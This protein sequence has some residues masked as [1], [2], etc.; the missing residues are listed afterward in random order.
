MRAV[1]FCLMQF[2][3]LAERLLPICE[4]FGTLPPKPTTTNVGEDVSA[5]SVF[6]NAFLLLVRLW[7]FHRAPVE[8]CILG[9]GAPVGAEMNLEYLLQLRNAQLSAS[10]VVSSSSS[11]NSPGTQ[12]ISLDSFPKLKAWYV[13]HSASIA[14]TLSSLARGHPVHQHVDRLLSM[15]LKKQSK[16]AIS[17]MSSSSSSV[18]SGGEETSGRPNLSAWEVM[19]ATPYIV[20]AVL[21]ACA[22]GKLAPR[23]LTTGWQIFLNCGKSIV[24]L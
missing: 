19:T 2:P 14:A 12:L 21:A 6:S 15:M 11:S 4:F 23:D 8:Y 3:E 16:G 5:Y 24:S 20:D 9:N 10:G 22:H 1:V 7:N 17:P 18:M 13:Q